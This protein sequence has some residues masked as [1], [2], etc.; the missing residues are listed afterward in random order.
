MNR[1]VMLVLAAGVAAAL[2]LGACSGGTDQVSIVGFGPG[3]DEEP[4]PAGTSPH[5]TTVQ[6]PPTTTTTTDTTTATTTTTTT[7]SS[8][9]W[10]CYDIT[11]QGAPNPA[12][13]ICVGSETFVSTL[14]TCACGGNCITPCTDFCVN[15]LPVAGACLTCLTTTCS[16]AWTDCQ[17]DV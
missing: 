7:T 11:S 10:T 5:A 9:C 17:N 3:A 13:E 8:A 4:G 14:G 15:S 16:S 12:P 1:T 2:G 6:P